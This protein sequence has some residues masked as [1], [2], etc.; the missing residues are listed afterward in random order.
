MTPGG[1]PQQ[2]G[3]TFATSQAVT[4]VANAAAN[5]AQSVGVS[6][7]AQDAASQA[8]H[9]AALNNGSP[10]EQAAAARDA[11]VQ[12]DPSTTPEQAD[13]IYD[14][15]LAAATNPTLSAQ[16]GSSSRPRPGQIS[17]APP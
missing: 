5:A 6:V 13:A 11:A 4:D 12:A 16:P 8:A 1:A 10:T 9:N 3:Q 17:R 2:G 14:A 15:T 7:P